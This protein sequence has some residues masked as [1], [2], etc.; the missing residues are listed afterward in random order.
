MLNTAVVEELKV[1][2]ATKCPLFGMSG[3]Y[4]GVEGARGEVLGDRGMPYGR[5]VWAGGWRPDLY[6]VEVWKFRFR[7]MLVWLVERSTLRV[8]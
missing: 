5:V 8:E 4:E 7:F 2:R 6:T 1:D 3:V